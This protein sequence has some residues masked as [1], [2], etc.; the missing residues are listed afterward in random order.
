MV[1]SRAQTYRSSGF[2]PRAPLHNTHY[3]KFFKSATTPT[4]H[5]VRPG[6]AHHPH[7]YSNYHTDSSSSGIFRGFGE[8]GPEVSASVT[9]SLI[10][11]AE[12]PCGDH[13][14]RKLSQP[15]SHT[16]FLQSAWLRSRD[17]NHLAL[18]PHGAAN[19]FS[20]WPLPGVWKAA[21]R[22]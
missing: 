12:R 11:R 13:V 20:F 5:G 9:G 3:R 18:P 21:K 22:L 1:S 17:L 2:R 16:V 10:L 19:H 8:R 14:G 15:A 4:A 6:R 7:G